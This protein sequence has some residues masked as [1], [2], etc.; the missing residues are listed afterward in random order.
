MR[1]SNTGGFEATRVAPVRA[2]STCL[3]PIVIIAVLAVGSAVP[4]VGAPCKGLGH[5][6]SS[7]DAG[8]D[9]I[10][11]HELLRALEESHCWFKDVAMR[12]R[13]RVHGKHTNLEEVSEIIYRSNGGR[14]RCKGRIT[15]VNAAARTAVGTPLS[16]P[17]QVRFRTG[18]YRHGYIAGSHAR[19]GR[20]N[21][22][23]LVHGDALVQLWTR[24]LLF[25]KRRAQYC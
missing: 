19:I 17:V 11:A 18:A 2:R 12:V 13:T 8:M 1:L 25:R 6:A 5:M 3:S 21:G 16:D 15:T 23:R 4:S 10:G 14:T 24:G 20:R 9:E 7:D 22:R